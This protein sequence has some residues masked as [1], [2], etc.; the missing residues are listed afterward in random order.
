M[1]KIYLVGDISYKNYAKFTEEMANLEVE[2]SE[3]ITIEL[4]SEGGDAYASLA[5]VSRIRLSPCRIRILGVGYVASA[6]VLILACG[7]KKAMTEE[8]W[9]MVHEEFGAVDGNVALKEIEIR[10]CRRM[11]EQA[12]K[13]LSHYSKTEA[14]VWK[15]MH[16]ETTYL[17]ANEC[18][19]MGLIDEVI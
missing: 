11:E 15:R 5:F 19:G 7:D 17:T 18:L 6:A 1:R 16:K 13:A 2:S 10:Q 8:S 3:D 12:D 14:S 4:T 9:L